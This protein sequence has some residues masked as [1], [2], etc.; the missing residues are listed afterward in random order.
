MLLL[1]LAIFESPFGRVVRYLMRLCFHWYIDL[2]LQ[3]ARH[4]STFLSSEHNPRN[5]VPLT[6]QDIEPFC[7]ILD[8]HSELS[9]FF[10]KR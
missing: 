1:L 2:L 4:H 9:R 10:N 3:Y 8:V 5:I 7:N 6:R